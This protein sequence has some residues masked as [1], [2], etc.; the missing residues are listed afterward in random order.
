M[1]R[2]HLDSVRAAVNSTAMRDSARTTLDYAR[3]WVRGVLIT[4]LLAT[5]IALVG[6]SVAGGSFLGRASFSATY[7]AIWAPPELKAHWERLERIRE[8]DEDDKDPVRRNLRRMQQMQQ[9]VQTPPPWTGTWRQ[10]THDRLAAT[11]G[12]A[13]AFVVAGGWTAVATAWLRR[14]RERR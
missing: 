10:R 12:L 2:R 4:V 13:G 6:A 11:G 14:R 9:A 1:R 8:D 7:D 3:I 5:A